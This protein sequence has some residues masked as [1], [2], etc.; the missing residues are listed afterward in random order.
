M[1]H[2]HVF[3]VHIRVRTKTC[4]L[5]FSGRARSLEWWMII[6][7]SYLPCQDTYG[8]WSFFL[9]L[10]KLLLLG[11]FVSIRSRP[12]VLI[13]VDNIILLFLYK[14]QY[15]QSGCR[16]DH[17][18]TLS[19]KIKTFGRDP[20]LSKIWNQTALTMFLGQIECEGKTSSKFHSTSFSFPSLDERVRSNEE[21]S[22]AASV[23]GELSP[24]LKIPKIFKEK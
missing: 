21:E 23:T 12:N 20:N 9:T 10:T 2:V 18:N 1:Q 15:D 16:L 22:L 6:P 11:R 7:W 19:S 13:L 24:S 5:C 17:G 4:Q 8:I 3:Q 14:L